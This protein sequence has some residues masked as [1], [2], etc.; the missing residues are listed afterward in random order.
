MWTGALLP[1]SFLALATASPTKSG[2][3]L[4]SNVATINFSPTKNIN[5]TY[6]KVINVNVRKTSNKGRNIEILLFT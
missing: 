3:M 2:G 4:S 5:L 1:F 6:K